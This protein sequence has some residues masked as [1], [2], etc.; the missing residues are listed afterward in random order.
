VTI[1][2]LDG[3]TVLI[4]D[5]ENDSQLSLS[6]AG[7]VSGVYIVTAEYQGVYRR[8]KLVYLP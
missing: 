6:D 5:I 4:R 2:D 1:T 7:L 3:N 8:A